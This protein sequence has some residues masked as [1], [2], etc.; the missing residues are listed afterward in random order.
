[1]ISDKYG[2][3]LTVLESIAEKQNNKINLSIILIT[4]KC[5]YEEVPEIIV[6]FFK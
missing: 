3:D 1:M 4:L 2:K 5:G 6:N